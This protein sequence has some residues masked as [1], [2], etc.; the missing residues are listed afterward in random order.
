MFAAY[1]AELVCPNW[2][3][4]RRRKQDSGTE[5]RCSERE[6]RERFKNDWPTRLGVTYPNRGREIRA[7]E[8]GGAVDPNFSPL[9]PAR[10]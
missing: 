7:E 3:Q 6:E 2:E 10:R 9:P 5:Q 8:M 4:E 1:L